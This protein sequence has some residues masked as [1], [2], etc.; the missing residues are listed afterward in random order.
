[1]RGG[2]WLVLQFWEFLMVCTISERVVE[3]VDY[4]VSQI[5]KY[6]GTLNLKQYT[7]YQKEKKHIFE[8]N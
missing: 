1:M 6:R 3:V 5:D 4:T 8:D 2:G 7:K